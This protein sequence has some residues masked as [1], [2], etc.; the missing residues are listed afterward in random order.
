MQISTL[1]AVH[2]VPTP[3]KARIVKWQ[4]METAA[5]RL[6]ARIAACRVARTCKVQE[7][8]ITVNLN[9]P[10][11]DW[12]VSPNRITKKRLNQK[13]RTY[14]IEV[15]VNVENWTAIDEQGVRSFLSEE[16]MVC[17]AVR[18]LGGAAAAA[19]IDCGADEGE[20]RALLTELGASANGSNFLPTD[21]GE[22][23]SA[24]DELQTM[25]AVLECKDERGERD[26][27]RRDRFRKVVVDALSDQDLGRFDGSSSLVDQ[28][29]VILLVN[30]FEPAKRAVENALVR[31]GFRPDEF[32]TETDA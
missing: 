31:A 5:E 14:E 22:S 1:L 8:D 29:E 18:C 13:A 12:S 21:S 20:V 2:R 25:V 9:R 32:W 11:A 23:A 7:I 3:L 19:L 15:D 4:I 26:V 30:E 10:G 24:E 28:Y 6:E 27:E 17:E 16:D